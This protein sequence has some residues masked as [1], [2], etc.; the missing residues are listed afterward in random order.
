MSPN[1]HR[2]NEDHFSTGKFPAIIAFC[3]RDDN[4]HVQSGAEE[5]YEYTLNGQ[6]VYLLKKIASQ[7]ELVE[8]EDKKIVRVSTGRSLGLV[9]WQGLRFATMD[10][11]RQEERVN[12]LIPVKKVDLEKSLALM[13][14][15]GGYPGNFLDVTPELDI[16]V[17]RFVDPDVTFL[18]YSYVPAQYLEWLRA[19]LKDNGILEANSARTLWVYKK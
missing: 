9:L 7:W 11:G 13:Y 10:K 15:Y 2:A 3:D 1:P 16:I 19:V 5:S 4:T 14:Y 8:M 12:V 6:T 17:S 18:A